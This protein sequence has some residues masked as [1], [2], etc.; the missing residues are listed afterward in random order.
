MEL[1]NNF[2]M[3]L[4]WYPNNSWPGSEKEKR[5]IERWEIG[6]DRTIVRT[7]FHKRG[8]VLIMQRTQSNELSPTSS[9]GILTS[10]SDEK[11]GRRY[12]DIYYGKQETGKIL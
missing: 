10:H 1:K 7:K 11:N 6:E 8:G 9:K 3:F 4:P 12:R 2:L 5:S